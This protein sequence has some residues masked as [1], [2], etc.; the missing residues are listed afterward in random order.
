MKLRC[1]V[2][3]HDNGISN[4][5]TEDEAC[6]QKSEWLGKD[7]NPKYVPKILFSAFS[8]LSCL[9]ISH[10]SSR[11][12]CLLEKQ[13]EPLMW[14]EHDAGQRLSTVLLSTA[15]L[16]TS[17]DS[18]CARRAAVKQSTQSALLSSGSAGTADG[19]KASA[20]LHPVVN[21]GNALQREKT[22]P[23]Y[24]VYPWQSTSHLKQKKAVCLYRHGG[25]GTCLL[26]C[27]G[28]WNVSDL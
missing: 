16:V 17:E 20:L 19:L 15:V 27:M 2:F 9:R 23:I 13:K 21:S 4:T 7:F 12:A 10:A 3:D 25:W 28:E 18:Q 6:C 8:E 14:H 26:Q 5:S 22:S 11:T 1:S 24:Q